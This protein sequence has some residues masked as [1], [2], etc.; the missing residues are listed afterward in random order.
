MADHTGYTATIRGGD[1][2]KG[3][4]R[5]SGSSMETKITSGIIENSIRIPSHPQEEGVTLIFSSFVGS[6]P[7][8]T[9][10][11]LPPPPKKKKKYLYHMYQEFQ[12]P[13][14]IFHILSTP[15]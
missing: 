8:S 11:P 12:E 1:L 5:G 13:L 2:A 15:N 4:D 3:M 10:Y 6:G 7:A 14:K 9:V